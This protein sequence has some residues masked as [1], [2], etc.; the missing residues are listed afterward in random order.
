MRY[1]TLVVLMSFINIMA[2]AQVELPEGQLEASGDTIALFGF[3]SYSEAL[4][5]TEDYKIALSQITKIEEQYD[6][7]Y[8]RVEQEFNVKYEEFLEGQG[9]FPASILRKRQAELQELMDKNIAFRKEASKLLDS[10]R[11][12]VFKPAHEKLATAIARTATSLGLAFVVNTDNNTYPFIDPK[13]G[14]DITRMVLENIQ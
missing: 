9:E 11:V 12:E 7:E 14:I 10:A 4:E 5:Q 6:A 3:M 13:R 1:L 2:W 8:K